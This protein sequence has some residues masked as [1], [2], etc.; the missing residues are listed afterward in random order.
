ML[1]RCPVKALCCANALAQ[2]WTFMRSVAS[3]DAHVSSQSALSSKRFSTNFAFERL[4]A[5]MRAKMLCQFSRTRTR[6]IARS[7]HVWCDEHVSSRVNS[8]TAS[9]RKRFITLSAFERLLARMYA[10]VHCQTIRVTKIS[11]ADFTDMSSSS[12]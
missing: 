1:A 11:I 3:M 9:L 8:Q 6:L 2:T 10:R 4:L 12:S 5:S 7:T